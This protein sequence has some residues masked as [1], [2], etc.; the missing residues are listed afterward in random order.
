MASTPE[1]LVKQKVVK[2]LK[3]QGIYYFS[4]MTHGFGRSGVPDI[5][6]CIDGKFLG[7]ECKAGSNKPTALQEKEMQAIRDAGGRA[8]VINEHNLTLLGD[9]LKE[10][11]DGERNI[12]ANRSS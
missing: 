4:P 10:M 6:C 9:L 12:G 8:V 5:I 3:A 1:K 11:V 2:L 7:I